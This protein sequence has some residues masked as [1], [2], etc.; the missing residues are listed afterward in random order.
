M[1]KW[2]GLTL[3][4]LAT[5]VLAQGI[6]P[7]GNTIPPGGLGFP[8]TPAQGALIANGVGNPPATVGPSNYDV[9]GWNGSGIAAPQ[10]IIVSTT[11]EL[12]AIPITST[13]AHAIVIKMGYRVAG[14]MTPIS[15]YLQS[16]ACDL[17]AGAG[18]GGAEFPSNTAG[19]CWHI[20]QASFYDL[21]WW[22]G[23][24]DV[25]N[26]D[27]QAAPGVV[28]TT[29]GS[30]NVTKADGV[31]TQTDI[32]KLITISDDFG[33]ATTPM[34]AS[35]QGTIATVVDSTHLTVTPN[36]GF[37]TNLP[38]YVA[39]GH[40]DTVA[41]NAMALY[42]SSLK[43]RPTDFIGMTGG[44]GNFGFTGPFLMPSATSL[45]DMSLTAMA[46]G[47][48]TCSN[49]VFV[50]NG[51]TTWPS[52]IA[53]DSNYLPVTGYRANQNGSTNLDN[54]TIRHWAG[55]CGTPIT[56]SFSSAG[57]G[58]YVLTVS[59]A[60]P[61][62]TFMVSRGNTG[63]GIPDRAMIVGVVTNTTNTTCNTHQC[64]V[65]SRP[66]MGTL[67]NASVTWVEDAHGINVVNNSVPQAHNK[68]AG[69]HMINTNIDEV[70]PNGAPLNN[71]SG[72]HY[73]CG[74]LIS[75]SQNDF[76]RFYVQGGAATTCFDSF[77]S[78]YAFTSTSVFNTNYSPADPLAPAFLLA[79]GALNFNFDSGSVAGIFQHFLFDN[80]AAQDGIGLASMQWA[81]LSV[82]LIQYITN[83]T[84]ADL[85][86]III[87]QNAQFAGNNTTAGG[88]VTFTGPGTCGV[89][90][91]YL[92]YSCAQLANITALNNGFYQP[93][94]GTP[95]TV[96]GAN[97]LGFPLSSALHT[98]IPKTTAFAV[99]PTT[100]CFAYFDIQQAAS[101]F[102][103][104]LPATAPDGCEVGLTAR[105]SGT[106][107]LVGDGTSL[108]NGA[109]GTTKNLTQWIRE[110][111]SVS[112]GS[113]TTAE[114]SCP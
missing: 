63:A 97:L 108:I 24:G 112:H 49:A 26:N 82:P 41:A 12:Q 59:D 25:Q 101:S 111:C 107:T 5:P 46:T 1:F 75:G 100:Q 99:D 79:M 66:T 68:G 95:L 56:G 30:P 47:T 32:G 93:S 14:D 27:F 64:I 104:T 98:K 72:D 58:S 74:L 67:T 57:T 33:D 11:S 9:L 114:W 71:A 92:Q 8:Q 73:G 6:G 76:V 80:E 91:S 78:G 109:T 23:Y 40:A 102:N 96:P 61:Y 53:I 86:E 113:G 87:G 62:K 18:D 50:A 106:I 88:F 69:I 10:R 43:S 7:G 17:G 94:G 54:S 83:Q 45:V 21:H 48:F 55:S 15:Y 90:Y 89:Q 44:G 60:T 42:V 38:Q 85:S 36:V 22:G 103:V 81:P 2:L 70:E 65:I 35:Y 84:N 28:T 31:F 51:T 19:F 3:G 16:N 37:S 20:S 77:S 110:T 105:G 39:Y 52:N 4:L 13:T 29:S 34:G